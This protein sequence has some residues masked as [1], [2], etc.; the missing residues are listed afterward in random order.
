MIPF[1]Q[2]VTNLQLNMFETFMSESYR[3]LCET[4]SNYESE[5]I[6]MESWYTQRWAPLKAEAM[7]EFNKRLAELEAEYVKVQELPEL[8]AESAAAYIQEHMQDLEVNGDYILMALGEAD[9]Y[10]S[11]QADSG[12]AIRDNAY[13]ELLPV[14]IR[15]QNLEQFNYL[16]R[17][18]D[19]DG[20]LQDRLAIQPDVTRS[21]ICYQSDS[22]LA[23]KH[24]TDSDNYK[25]FV[26]ETERAEPCCRQVWELYFADW[27]VTGGAGAEFQRIL[28]MFDRKVMA[29]DGRSGGVVGLAKF[30][31]V[32]NLIIRALETNDKKLPLLSA[33]W[34]EEQARLLKE[35]Q[36]KL[37]QERAQREST[38]LAKGM[39]S[40]VMYNLE[41]MTP[42]ELVRL[43]A[44]AAS[45]ALSKER[46]AKL[47]EQSA[48]LFVPMTTKTFSDLFNIFHMANT[49]FPAKYMS[50]ALDCVL[51]QQAGALEVKLMLMGI[52]HY[53]TRSAAHAQKFSEV[54]GKIPA[55]RVRAFK[56]KIVALGYSPTSNELSALEELERVTS[57]S[58]NGIN[59]D[60]L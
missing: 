20:W 22:E 40:G 13:Q 46:A 4:F 60:D 26:I 1:Y 58:M 39:T 55:S 23:E 59:L 15:E 50:E 32:K 12:K 25:V 27:C 28:S 53:L 54:S 49:G 31:M 34:A 6:A 3:D 24:G 44:E 37:E 45:A 41:Q 8:T 47:H 11:Q 42:D 9:Y 7:Q 16:Q 2:L 57:V 38:I 19:L 10:D 56:N 30:Q 52:Q 51:R 29:T 21:N 5:M 18:A 33:M 48:S 35:Q 17:K 43:S 36:E 14:Y